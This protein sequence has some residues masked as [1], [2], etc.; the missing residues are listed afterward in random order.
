MALLCTQNQVQNSKPSIKDSSILCLLNSAPTN[1]IYL[2]DKIVFPL[3]TE[4]VS[5]FSMSYNI[6][7]STTNTVDYQ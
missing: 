6:Y 7:L 2:P 5:Y 4:T 3:K 1:Q